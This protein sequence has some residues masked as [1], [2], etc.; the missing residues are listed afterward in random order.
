MAMGLIMKLGEE[1]R[2]ALSAVPYLGR[3]D[4]QRIGGE[5]SNLNVP[6]PLSLLRK[7]GDGAQGIERRW[8]C[9]ILV[10]NHYICIFY[11]TYPNKICSR[12]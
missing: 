9:Q 4:R 5:G 8:L 1:C 11:L 12:N 2:S 6:G 3:L 7:A 10:F